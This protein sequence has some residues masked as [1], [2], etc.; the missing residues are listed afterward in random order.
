MDLTLTPTQAE[1][2][3]E[4]REWLERSVPAERLAP[5]STPEGLAAR[6]A[7]ERSLWEA[8]FA[9][10]HWPAEYGGRGMD[11]VST[12][13]FYDEYLRAGAPDRL[14][15]LGLGLGGPTIIDH[16]TP[17]QRARWL[18]GILSCDELWCQ[19]FSEPAAGSDLAALRTRGRVDGDV[20]VVDGQKTWTSHS[21]VAD[22]MFAL[23]RTDPDAPKHRGITFV[24]ID[25]RAPGV[26]V[27]P[28]RQ[29]NDVSG[30]SEVFFDDVRVPL[31]NVVG[32]MNDG[33]RVAMTT[34]THERGSGLNTAGHFRALL[35]E[36][37]GM[38]S[39]ERRADPRVRATIGRLSEEIEAY[40]YMTLR[41]LTQ[42]SAGRTPGAQSAM[43]KLWWSELQTRIFELGLSA[44]G[45]AAILADG[46]EEG[47]TFRQRY[48][49][50]R[51]AHIYAGSNEIQ[52]N[53][54]SERVL[55]LPK[56]GVRGV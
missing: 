19:G 35:V 34:L 48:W 30:F 22:W 8:G 21:S 52:R 37:V 33:W 25:M 42:L 26:T 10:V 50:S 18:P 2:R 56:G 47:Q 29:L 24:M 5:A 3:D 43:G 27:R 44:L 46:A 51:A 41:T 1:F 45:D 15:R 20:L 55:G 36:V 38:L 16:G 54:I 11:A 6:V 23:V 32:P 49:L 14:N 40:R 28:I 31:G 9:A 12:A 7:W 53:I 39:P 4:V 17:A 13:I